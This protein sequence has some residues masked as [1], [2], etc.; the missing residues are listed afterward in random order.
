VAEPFALMTVEEAAA[1]LRIAPKT[2]FN[3]RVRSE[4]PPALKVGGR[5]R[6]RRADLDE[7]LDTECREGG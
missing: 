3:W 2:L 7:W 6:Y 4:G 1:Y 5:V